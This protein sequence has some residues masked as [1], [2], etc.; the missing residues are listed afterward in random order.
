MMHS[1]QKV[2]AQVRVVVGSVN[3]ALERD[4]GLNRG[5]GVERTLHTDIYNK[6]LTRRVSY[7]EVDNK[8]MT[9]QVCIGT[10]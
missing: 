9:D 7:K 1:R 5:I 2:C 6:S 4:Q 3:G 10:F 8:S